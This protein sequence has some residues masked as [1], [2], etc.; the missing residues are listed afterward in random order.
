LFDFYEDIGFV[1]ISHLDLRILVFVDQSLGSAVKTEVFVRLAAGLCVF[2]FSALDPFLVHYYS[3]LSLPVASLAAAGF[4][5]SPSVSVHK[6][7]RP[8]SH[9][10][11]CRPRVRVRPSPLISL[12]LVSSRRY[13]V[14]AEG[15]FR[16]RLVVS[17]GFTAVVR[18][19]AL[20]WI[21]LSL[22]FHFGLCAGQVRFFFPLST[23]SCRSPH[24]FSVPAVSS[25]CPVP[26]SPV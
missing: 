3:W 19:P 26:P 17:F 23:V 11:I 15:F 5:C 25:P 18:V 6:A 1:P 9:C 12:L 24:G 14:L 21:F 2:V 10:Q 20:L 7:C 22:V 13:G 4:I 8:V 16:A